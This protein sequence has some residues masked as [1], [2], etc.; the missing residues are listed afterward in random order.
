ME[1]KKEALIRAVKFAVTKYG[2]AG[3]STRNVGEL[4]Q[5]NDAYI[6]R[7]FRNKE[8]LLLQA[9]QYENGQ[10]FQTLLREIDKAH[11]FALSLCEKGRICFDTV[12]K[13]ML[14]DPDRLTA[15][16]IDGNGFQNRSGCCCILISRKGGCS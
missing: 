5:V 13:E 7:I 10:I 1:E 4:A 14:S 16:R 9:Y 2:I 6:Y 8:D 11:E 12:W 15:D 3:I